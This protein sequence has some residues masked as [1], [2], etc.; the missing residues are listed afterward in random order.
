L[1]YSFNGTTN[2]TTANTFSTTTA[3]PVTACK[4]ANN[5]QIGPLSITIA[6]IDQI[7]DITI[8]DSG[9]DCST[10]PPGGNILQ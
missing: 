5:C 6:A 9:Y 7:T 8:T 1:Q 4:D 3:G 10:T 2:F